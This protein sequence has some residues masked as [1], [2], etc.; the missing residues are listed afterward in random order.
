M[1]R[2]TWWRLV[3]WGTVASLC[4]GS[5]VTSLQADDS[6]RCDNQIVRIGFSTY[7]VQA[8]C[9]PPDFADRRVSERAVRNRV[10]GRCAPGLGC[11]TS[12]TDKIQI[13]LD[14]WVYDF[15]KNRFTQYLTFEDGTLVSSRSG[16]Y[17]HKVQ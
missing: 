2:Q 6:L 12:T 11:S 7:D 1:W 9:G 5:S 13:V 3:S 17:G 4:V 10:R 16:N 15:G 14:E 8:L